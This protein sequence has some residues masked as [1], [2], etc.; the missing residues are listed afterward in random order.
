M[1]KQFSNN[2]VEISVAKDNETGKNIEHYCHPVDASKKAT[3]LIHLINTKNGKKHLLIA[4]FTRTKHGANRL[5]PDG[6]K[7][8]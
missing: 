8:Y 3:L 4:L 2:P 6:Y 1:V 5:I 7:T